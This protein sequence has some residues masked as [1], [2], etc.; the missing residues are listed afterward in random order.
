MTETETGTGTTISEE[1]TTLTDGFDLVDPGFGIGE[2]FCLG[3]HLARRSQQALF[4]E[5]ARRVESLEL[6]G[7]PEWIRSSFVVGLKKL[8]MRYRIAPASG[9]A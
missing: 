3:S 7:E 9:R 4:R 8:P 6:A 1:R 2:H 5:L